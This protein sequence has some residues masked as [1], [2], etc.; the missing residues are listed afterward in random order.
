MPSLLLWS[1]RRR[2]F[3]NGRR[4]PPQVSEPPSPQPSPATLLGLHEEVLHT[5]HSGDPSSA[6]GG[7]SC[8]DEHWRVPSSS[9]PRADDKKM[10]ETTAPPLK[11]ASGPRGPTRQPHEALTSDPLRKAYFLS[12]RILFFQLTAC[13]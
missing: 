4:P 10:K 3:P 7:W 13:L 5:E 11:L 9:A 12:R 2:G 1:A 8:R 6:E